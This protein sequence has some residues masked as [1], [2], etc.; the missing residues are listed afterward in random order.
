MDVVVKAKINFN[1]VT[2]YNIVNIAF[3]GTTYTLTDSNSNT[4]TYAAAQY[5]I[6]ILFKEG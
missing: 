3:D 6:Q 2:H 4:Y 5:F 1:C